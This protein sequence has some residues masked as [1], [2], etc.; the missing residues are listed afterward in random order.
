MN[1]KIKIFTAGLFTVTVAVI[2]FAFVVNKPFDTIKVEG[3]IISG[4][5]NPSGDIHIFKGG[6]WSK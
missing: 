5:I 2:S 1:N 3:G 4:T 6:P